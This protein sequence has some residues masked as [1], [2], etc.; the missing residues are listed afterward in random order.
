MSKIL[1]NL[2]QVVQKSLIYN[3]SAGV[4]ACVKQLISFAGLGSDSNY[5]SR[6]R[7]NF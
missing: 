6:P 5:N 2:E 3:Q 7:R 1:V 4:A